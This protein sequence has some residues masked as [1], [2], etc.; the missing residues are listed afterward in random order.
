MKTSITS[1]A[2]D[3]LSGRKM[4][5][6]IEHPILRTKQKDEVIKPYRSAVKIHRARTQGRAILGRVAD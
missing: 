5:S 1:L 3:S 6:L 2:N 4:K